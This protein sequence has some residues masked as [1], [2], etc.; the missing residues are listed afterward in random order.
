MANEYV[1]LAEM[2]AL[3]GIDDDAE[4]TRLG[5]ALVSASRAIDAWCG[6]RFYKDTSA[7]A[8]KLFAGPADVVDLTAQGCEFYDTD[9]LVVKLDEGDD[10]T[11]ERTLT[12]SEYQLEPVNGLRGGVPGWP[13]TRIVALDLRWFP[14]HRH[15]PGVE[16]TAKWGWAAVPEPVKQATRLLTTAGWK[17]KDAA[18]G[19]AGFDGFAMRLREDPDMRAM[20]RPFR[21]P[22]IG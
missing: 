4:D 1:T 11:F 8:R 6:R 17:R 12:A 2:K 22:G 10:G 9:G 7:S 3:H 19:I 18:F 21:R 16:V 15:R 14:M 20:L 5:W 13:Y